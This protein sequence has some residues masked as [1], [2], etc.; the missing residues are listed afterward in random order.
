[1]KKI[2]RNNPCYCGSGKKYNNCCLNLKPSGSYM[3]PS[4]KSLDTYSEEDVVKQLI[5]SSPSFKNYYETERESIG[6]ILWIKS[7]KDAELT[8]G[9]QKGQKGKALW[10]GKKTDI[11]KII[12]LEQIPPSLDD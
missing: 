7:N 3:L 2:G 6:E 10:F 9:F 8:F 11:K 1:M 5:S 4:G 12:I